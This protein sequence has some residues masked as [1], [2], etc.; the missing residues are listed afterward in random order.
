MKKR[1]IIFS[2]LILSVVLS[3]LASK[4]EVV[5]KNDKKGSGVI[6][7]LN[8][9]VL[10]R[11]KQKSTELSSSEMDEMSQIRKQLRKDLSRVG[12]LEDVRSVVLKDKEKI[13]G[14]LKSVM[15]KLMNSNL[16]TKS[17]A[18]LLEK[19]EMLREQKS[20]ADMKE[21]VLSQFGPRSR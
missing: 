14:Q 20:L 6:E 4:A 10:L 19:K 8:H 2:F 7:T 1:S 15:K 11:Y 3:V 9:F 16:S 5:V 21:K 17:R 18:S 13:D 12:A